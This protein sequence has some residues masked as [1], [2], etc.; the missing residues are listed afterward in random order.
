VSAYVKKV[1]GYLLFFHPAAKEQKSNI[2]QSSH[3]IA[4]ENQDPHGLVKI[5]DD[6][7]FFK[8]CVAADVSRRNLNK[9]EPYGA[10]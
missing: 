3:I 5:R 6:Y 4:D 1:T 7:S 8:K 10:N 2:R 9:E